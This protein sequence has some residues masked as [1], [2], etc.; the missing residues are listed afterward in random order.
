MNQS[1]LTSATVP[2]R[3]VKAVKFGYRPT[4]ITI[5]LL[6]T[7][8]N[9][10]NDA[11][12]ICLNENIFGRLKLIEREWKCP[13]CGATLDRDLNAAIN[14]ER[15]GKIPCLGAAR[16]G[17]RGTDEAMKGNPTTPVILRAEALN[18]TEP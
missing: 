10:V 16:P 17:A 14:I 4:P 15:R 9:M 1:D 5:D 11:I 18:S 12:R 7:F 6:K 3:T 8:R 13:S 2:L